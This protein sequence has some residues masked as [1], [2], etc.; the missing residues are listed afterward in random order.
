MAL[1]LRAFSAPRRAVNRSKRRAA[2][3]ATAASLALAGVGAA[4]VYASGNPG[5]PEIPVVSANTLSVPDSAFSIPA[6]ATFVAPNGSDRNPG[7]AAAPFLTVSHAVAAARPG[8]TV[9]VRGGTY[10][11]SLGI[12]TKRITIQAYPHEQ[13]WL[14][15]S[16]PV[17]GFAQSGTTWVKSGWSSALCHTCYSSS[18]IDPAYPAAGLPDQ[19]FVDGVP[20]TQVTRSNDVTPG[21]FYVDVR[22]HR[23]L[24]GDNPAGHTVEATNQAIAM[25]FE[26]TSSGSRLLGI[27][28]MQYGPHFDFDQ[29][30]MVI[31]NATNLTFENDAFDWSATRGLSVLQPGGVVELSTF[32]YNGANGLHANR[33]DG[34]LVSGDHFAYNNYEHFSIAS[35]ASASIAAMKVTYTQNAVVQWNVFDDNDSNAIWFDLDGYN[36]TIAHNWIARNA[37]MGVMYEVS[38]RADITGNLITDSGR[39]GVRI[40]GSTNTQVSSNWLL[41]NNGA[42]LGVY[43]D[44]RTQPNPELRRMGITWDT[45]GISASHNVFGAG[46][47][48]SAPLFDSFDAGHPHRRTTLQ[49]LATDT[50]NVFVQPANVSAAPV[51]E[52]QTSLQA[53]TRWPSLVALQQAT[54]HERGSRTVTSIG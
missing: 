11:E 38:S 39:D 17:T 54:G 52:W 40:S 46:P 45:A 33:A 31:G 9:V 37:G 34:F 3:V 50:D 30:A 1:P 6:G 29:P 4:R 42:Q 2:A 44:P 13:V 14:K 47:G 12:V 49:M 5:S 51:A 16:V 22:G 20:L 8:G 35:T 15:G 23:L 25:Q 10:R 21:T 53:L 7:T 26:R 48:A 27:G 24:L 36:V 28:V 43:E 18:A 19:V 32:L 41:D